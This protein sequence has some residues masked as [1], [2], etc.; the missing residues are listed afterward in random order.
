MI[1]QIS[2]QQALEIKDKVTVVDVRSPEEYCHA[3]IPGAVNLPLFS[4]EQRKEI[5]TLYKQRSKNEAMMRAL[6]FY[7]PNMKGILEKLSSIGASKELLIYC[8]RGGMRSE[9]VGWMLG[10]F[11]YEV[12]KIIGGYKQFRNW[13]LSSF[14]T[15][16]KINIIG[17]KTGSGKTVLLQSL[18]DLGEQIIDLEGL[19]GHRGSAFGGIGRDRFLS[20]EHFENELA[21]S[22]AQFNHSKPIW[23]E[24]ES[25]RIGYNDIP[26]P[27]WIQMREARVYYLD[28]PFKERLGHIVEMYSMHTVTE[29]KE[30]T[31]RIKK[32]LGGLQMQQT[33]DYLDKNE[34]SEAFSILLHHYDKLYDQSLLKRD[35]QAITLVSSSKVDPF[36]NATLLRQYA[37]NRHTCEAH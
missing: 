1:E 7:S 30:A 16:L 37:T 34:F 11:G 2:I 19:A 20:Q 29:L 14:Q 4:D 9:T 36:L 21:I 10:L 3:H 25:Q 27:L 35:Q 33:L 18:R 13:T 6:D 28:I 22:L 26:R 24:D 32:K 23:I 17:G 31:L 15:P 5:G 12:K 8:W